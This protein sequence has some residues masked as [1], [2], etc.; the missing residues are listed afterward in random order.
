MIDGK[1]T[2]YERIMTAL[3]GGKP[4]RVPVLPFMRDWGMNYAGFTFSEV[5]ENPSKYVYAQYRAL[6]DIGGDVIWDL[7]GAHSESEAM[8]S[9]IEIHPDSPPSV[10]EFAVKDLSLDL[11]KLRLPN[12][13]KDGRLP[14]LLMVVRRLK[15]LVR[16]EVPVIGYVQG[17]LRHAAMLR[18]TEALL[19]EMNK[20]KDKCDELFRIATDSLILYGA[21]LVDAG[22]DL[23]MIAEPYMSGDMLSKK[24]AEQVAP[25]FR[26]LS[27]TL[28]KTRAR[29]FVH[30][31][32]DFNDRF[33]T[34]KLMDAHGVSLDEKNDLAK[35]REIMGPEMCLIGNV[36][37][38]DALA[39][40]TP[41]KVLEESKRAFKAAGENGAFILASGCMIPSI[42]PQENLEALINFA[43]DSKY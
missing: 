29:V 32:G 19:K 1:M 7:M 5:L 25:H 26:R 28:K 38:T 27:Q 42:A 36:N 2:S 37:P 10:V 22:A 21:A 6:R 34:I 40:G 23:I 3:D 8:G 18:G 14:E 33:D 15:E 31:C 39:L 43:K 20:A 35:A 30:L 11:E 12:P 24:M 9:V 17:P 16:E 4:D 13:Y 41:D